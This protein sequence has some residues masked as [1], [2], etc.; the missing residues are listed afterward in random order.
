MYKE[1]RVLEMEAAM[2]APTV[3]QSMIQWLQLGRGKEEGQG[4]GGK[5]T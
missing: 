4:K 2:H 3:D 5:A 1:L